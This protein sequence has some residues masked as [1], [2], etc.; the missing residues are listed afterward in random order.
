[1]WKELISSQTDAAQ[2]VAPASHQQIAALESA[3][4]TPLPADLADLLCES[5]GVVINYYLDED[6]RV[7]CDVDENDIDK[8]NLH[9]AW[10]TERIERENLRIRKEPDLKT[11]YMPFGH[12][13]FFSDAANGDL[14]AYAILDG[15]VRNDDI[16]VWSH[17]DDSRRWIARSLETYIEGWLNGS[18][19]W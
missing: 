2:F 10:S 11:L 14:F 1:M 8:F 7:E 18:L 6:A 17:E 4:K 16:Y 5:N 12:L 9:V 13:L 19:K 3:L 15:V